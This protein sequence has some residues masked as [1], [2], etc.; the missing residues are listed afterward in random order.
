MRSTKIINVISCHAEGEVGNVIVGG[1]AD[2]PGK[3]ILQKSNWIENN[4]VLRNFLLNEP[5]G[6]VFKHFNL[7][8]PPKNK[9]AAFGFIIMSPEHNAPMSGSNSI[10]VATVLLDSGLIPIKEPET[11]FFL[12]VPAG[13]IEVKAHCFNG[14]AERIEIKNVTSFADKI[15]R[16]LEI[17]G[18]GTLKVDTAFFCF[19]CFFL[20]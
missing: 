18:I 8:V 1:V 5:R 17:K 3:S 12:E 9:K 20:T 2:P 10:C 11:S 13:L 6:G 4:Q 15:N 16:Y 19:S 14:K 7:L